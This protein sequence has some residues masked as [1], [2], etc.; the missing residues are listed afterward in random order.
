[1]FIIPRDLISL[2]HSIA[3]WN[4]VAVRE[5]RDSRTV[6]IRFMQGKHARS[7]NTL[8]DYYQVNSITGNYRGLL[9]ITRLTENFVRHDLINA[10]VQEQG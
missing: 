5:D 2:T 10:R 3:S 7:A 8:S 4:N 1:M 6:R 9:K